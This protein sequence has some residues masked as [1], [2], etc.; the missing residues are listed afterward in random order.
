[1]HNFPVYRVAL[2][3]SLLWLIM[4]MIAIAMLGKV[5]GYS[6]ALGGLISLLP[7][8]YFM[9]R[10]FLVSGAHAMEQ[11]V[12]NAYIA[13]AIKLGLIGLGF[14]AVFKLVTPLSPAGV[15][16][17]FLVMHVAGLVVTASKLNGKRN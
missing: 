16:G 1:M 7:G 14:M 10:Y 12:R 2:Y 8:V 4:F 11:V 6:V 15:F 9:F 3:Q 13:E 5:G 17:G